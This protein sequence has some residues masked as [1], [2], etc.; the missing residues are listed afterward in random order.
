MST[1]GI[2]ERGEADPKYAKLKPGPGRSAQEVR[3]N[4]R[5]RLQR[6]VVQLA[7]ERGPDG[8]TVRSLSKLAGVSTATFYT[9]FRNTDECFGK[10]CES[11][12]DRALEQMTAL[13]AGSPDWETRVRRGVDA[14][15]RFVAR[16]PSAARLVLVEAVPFGPENRQRLDHPGRKFELALVDLIPG[17]RGRGEAGERLAAAMM[18]GVTRVLRA[19]TIAGRADELPSFA[20]ELASWLVGV[21]T[22]DVPVVPPRTAASRHRHR[23]PRV[24]RA[25]DRPPRPVSVVD[26]RKMIVK[27]TVKLASKGGYASLTVPRIRSAAGV[28]RRS[29]NR[30]F[31]D[32][33]DCF[34][35]SIEWLAIESASSAVSRA[36]RDNG[37]EPSPRQL[38]LALS[39]Q[40]ARSE[41]LAALV[42]NDV[43]DAGR[44]GLF[45]EERLVSMAAIALE[46]QGSID[47]QAP[48]L[49]TEATVAALWRITANEILHGRTNQL[50][51][52]TS[53]LAD[54]TARATSG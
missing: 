19:T 22:I 1:A 12:M 50:P 35:Q 49:G 43:R 30:Y 15:F 53:S 8:V 41:A 25:S 10:T 7:S 45:A 26:D 42:F 4:Q 29:F 39:R 14:L 52:L 23:E 20:D 36:K 33:R 3:E 54:L 2:A 28:S 48:T 13:C 40:V 47:E 6:A 27:A 37:A 46:R 11:T 38:I 18:A 17:L 5:T 16:R 51:R 21:S 34:L 24:T 31:A 9:H 44:D 32:A